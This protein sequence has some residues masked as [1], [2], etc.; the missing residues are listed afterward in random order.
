MHTQFSNFGM[1]AIG[2]SQISKVL[3]IKNQTLSG[4]KN[5]SHKDHRD[6]VLSQ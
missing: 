6:L 2:G 3:Q 1:Q 5:E 4:Q